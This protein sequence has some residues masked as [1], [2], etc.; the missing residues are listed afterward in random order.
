MKGIL[1][2]LILLSLSVTG[3]NQSRLTVKSAETYDFIL[4]VNDAVVNNVACLSITLDNIT[5]GKV[6]VKASIPSHPEI[7]ISQIITLKKYGYAFYEI[8]KSKGKYKLILKSESSTHVIETNIGSIPEDQEPKTDL[9]TDVQLIEAIEVVGPGGCESPV[10]PDVYD[11]MLKEVS[12]NFFETRKLDV[13]KNFIAQHCVRVEQMRFMMS[14]LSLEDN[15]LD[16]LQTGISH[17]HDPNNLKKVE[18]DFFLAKNKARV[19]VLISEHR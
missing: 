2:T 5:E 3:W 10:D 18:D 11:K 4:T 7:I 12:D 17:V 6:A 9:Q 15:K 1:I 14:R 8:E 19:Q 13:M 16:L